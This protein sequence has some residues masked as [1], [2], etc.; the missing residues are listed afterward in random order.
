VNLVRRL[1]A[2]RRRWAVRRWQLTDP[3]AYAAQRSQAQAM[4]EEEGDK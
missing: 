4:R 2:W 3:T 1:L